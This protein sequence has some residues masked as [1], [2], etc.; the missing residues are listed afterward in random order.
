M[1]MT[2]PGIRETPAP[3]R[4]ERELVR[5][6]TEYHYSGLVTVIAENRDELAAACA[7]V[8]QP[9]VR[10]APRGTPCLR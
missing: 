3:E 6:H 5:G 1:Q 9:S 8:E 4:R 10:S 7:Q 2:R